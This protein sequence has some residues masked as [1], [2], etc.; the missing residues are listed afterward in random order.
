MGELYLFQF[1]YKSLRDISYPEKE[2]LELIKDLKKSNFYCKIFSFFSLKCLERLIKQEKMVLKLSQILN[3][4][5][6]NGKK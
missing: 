4:R 1:R 3:K 2:T 5:K 6:K